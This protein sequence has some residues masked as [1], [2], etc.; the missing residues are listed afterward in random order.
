MKKLFF[1]YLCLICLSCLNNTQTNQTKE[2]L[3]EAKTK[4]VE[5]EPLD[6]AVEMQVDEEA[7]EVVKKEVIEPKEKVQEKIEKKDDQLQKEKI[8]QAIEPIKTKDETADNVVII[9]N[10]SE[11]NNLLKKHV[12][13]QGN[14]DYKG[15][16]NDATALNEYI[17][18]LEEH[19]PENSWSKN[20]KLAYYINLYNAGTVKLILENYPLKS[21]KDISSPW[22]RDWFTI[23]GTTYSIGDIENKILRKMNEPRIHF[24]IN[25]ASYSCPKLSNKAYTAAKMGAQLEATTHD[26]INDPK[27]NKITEESAMISEIFKWFEKDFT[28][29]GSLVDYLNKF[30]GIKIMPTTKVEYI[31]YDWSLNDSKTN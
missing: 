18:S 27:R 21:I 8:E 10:H 24:A 15:F 14:V 31:D 16:L 12:N 20:D 28:T 4:E 25:C 3:I 22:D 29:K 19:G 2:T 26:F 23:G 1:L 9:P 17:Q 7:Q 6:T 11:W 13:S 30:S 5:K